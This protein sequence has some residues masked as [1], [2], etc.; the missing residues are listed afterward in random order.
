MAYKTNDIMGN[1]TDNI[2]VGNQRGASLYSGVLND[3]RVSLEQKGTPARVQE[4]EMKSGGF[5]GTKVPMIVVSHPNP[6]TRFFDIGIIVN[7]NVLSFVLLGESVQ[8]TKKNKKEQLIAD[9]KS[10]QAMLVNPDELIYQQELSWR[11][12]IL[13]LVKAQFE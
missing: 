7:D 4:D 9:G 12:E 11:A 1:A 5:R 6:P 8:N 3:L 13:E 10:L 2:R